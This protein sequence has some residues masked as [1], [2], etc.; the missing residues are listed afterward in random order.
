VG[1]SLLAS[2][3]AALKFDFTPQGTQDFDWSGYTEIV[4][5]GANVP[6]AIVI[7]PVLSAPRL[8]S[9]NLIVTGAGG[10]PNASYTWYATTNLAAPVTWTPTA[11]TGNLDGAGAFSNAIPV[12]TTTPARF[13]R[14]HLP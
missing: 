3:V 10:T 14:L 4:L 9:G 2:N 1:Q 13:F 8:S 5:Q 7:P 6:S 12:S 11:I